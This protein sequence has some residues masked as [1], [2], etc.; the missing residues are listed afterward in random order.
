MCPSYASRGV[1]VAV[2]A[3]A[4]EVAEAAAN[5]GVAEKMPWAAGFGRY[6][7]RYHC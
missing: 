4:A 6:S 1:D 7:P 5:E 3:V 2:V